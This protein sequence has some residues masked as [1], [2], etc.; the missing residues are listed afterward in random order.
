M[1]TTQTVSD[2]RAAAAQLIFQMS[3]AHIMSSALQ[4]ALDL[5][6]A[7]KLAGGP[8][9]TTALAKAAGV[10]E[11][12]LY[13]ML[14]VLATVGIFTEE[15]PRTFALTPAAELVRS[16]RPGSLHA[17]ALWLTD[18]LLRRVHTDAMY[19]MKT[20]KTAAEHV[21]GMN[22][23]E[24]FAT[25]PDVSERFNRAMTSMSAAVIPAVLEAYDFSVIGTLVDVAGGHGEVLMSILKTHAAMKGVLFDRD[26]VIA[27]AKPRIEAEGLQGRCTTA[28]G[29]F[30]QAVPEGGDAYIMKHIIHDW[31]DE[32]AIAILRNIGKVLAGRP[33]GRVL[34]LESVIRPGNEPDLGK[35]IDIEMLLMPG[36]RER[37]EAEFDALF[38]RAGYTMTR[39]VPTK[40][41]L[42]VIEARPR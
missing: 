36:G 31:D 2:P 24:Y 14:R 6:I 4:V 25:H 16:D 27:G 42:S 38:A 10:L 21:L 32:Q 15:A 33:G 23:W 7:D 39:V 20:G 29:D 11:D 13:R 5:R 41:P 8:Q 28:S 12:P 22:D 30:F 26:H 37:T 3:T 9:T 17:I 1:A 40:S 34:L 35:L 19:T 18:P